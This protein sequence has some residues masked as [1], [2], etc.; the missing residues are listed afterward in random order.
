MNGSDSHN[1][2][3]WRADSPELQDHN[4][5]SRQRSR[6]LGNLDSEKRW[7][8]SGSQAPQETRQ[9][10][11][12][13]QPAISD[14]QTS[15]SST[16][17]TSRAGRLGPKPMDDA[18]F[19]GGADGYEGRYD[20][21]WRQGERHYLT[22]NISG[23]W[24]KAP[25]RNRAMSDANGDGSIPSRFGS[26]QPENRAGKD[27]ADIISRKSDPGEPFS[28]NLQGTNDGSDACNT[29][30]TAQPYP[31][32]QDAPCADPSKEQRPSY[33]QIKCPPVAQGQP[34]GP[35]G[36]L[37]NPW[38]NEDEID[39]KRQAHWHNAF[40]RLN[41]IAPKNGEGSSTSVQTNKRKCFSPFTFFRRV[42]SRVSKNLEDLTVRRN[43][44]LKLAKALLYFGAPPHRIESQLVAADATLNTKAEIVYLPNIVIVTM[45]GIEP[46]EAART[47]FVRSK[48]RLAL[49]SLHHVHLIYRD[50]LHDSMGAQDGIDGLRKILR[51][52]PIYPLKFRCF[53]AFVCSSIICVLA[54]GGSAVDMFIS[55][56][57]ASILQYL[58][59]SAANKSSMYANVYEISVSIFVAFVARGLSSIPGHVF[60]YSAISSAGV[61]LILPGFTVLISSLELMSKN[62]FCGSVR[63]VYAIIYTLFLGFG[64]TIGSDFYLVLDQ[65]ARRQYYHNSLAT[66]L[67]YTHGQFVFPNSTSHFNMVSGVIGAALHTNHT[68]DSS[69][70]IIKDANHGLPFMKDV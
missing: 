57:C 11:L 69:L 54:F 32:P 63:I 4:T 3:G 33:E 35:E 28:R 45:H 36:T 52:P 31:Q 58:G 21:L 19:H 61:V 39:A 12:R 56:I 6:S 42:P 17:L 53:L 62:I 23:D 47:Y 48:G 8:G 51:A 49:T 38:P 24:D 2:F 13:A 22:S 68:G 43:F 66:N 40:A 14:A 65:G 34:P 44:L 59:L 29:Q 9:I 64:L 25:Y 1:R 41:G 10:R 55:G 16:G 15:A 7:Q 20:R 27:I 46:E 30:F 67:T 18:C 26:N 5:I 60:C 70:K 37:S 50:V